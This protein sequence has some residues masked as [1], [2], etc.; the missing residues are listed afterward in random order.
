MTGYF[1]IFAR[2]VCG[3][4]TFFF[5]GGSTLQL[6]LGLGLLVFWSLPG[7]R[8]FWYYFTK[9]VETVQH[10]LITFS[11]TVKSACSGQLTAFW[12]MKLVFFE[13]SRP[14]ARIT[15]TLWVRITGRARIT[16]L[17]TVQSAGH[18]PCSY[19]RILLYSEMHD[20]F[21]PAQNA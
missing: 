4:F 10:K 5:G 20:L 15:S 1:S 6:L 18:W 11:Y 14:G 7:P 19:H 21:Q 12:P 13:I 16:F 9:S 2:N 8:P 17:Y 3:C